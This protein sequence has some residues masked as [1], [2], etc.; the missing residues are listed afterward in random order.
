[1]LKFS[2]NMCLKEKMFAKEVKNIYLEYCEIFFFWNGMFLF[3]YLFI[4]QT[5]AKATKVLLVFGCLYRHMY[6]WIDF[7]VY[8]D[9]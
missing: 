1:M 5:C 6:T 7:Y 8:R 3:I 2:K 4:W 9:L